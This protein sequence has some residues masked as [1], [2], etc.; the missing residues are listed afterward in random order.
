MQHQEQK[1]QSEQKTI[2][3]GC[4]AVHLNVFFKSLLFKT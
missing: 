1:Q 4:V 3:Y 2:I